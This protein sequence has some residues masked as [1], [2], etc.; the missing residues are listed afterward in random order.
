MVLYGLPRD[1]LHLIFRCGL[2]NRPCACMSPVPISRAQPKV[3]VPRTLHDLLNRQLSPEDLFAVSAQ[4]AYLR[5][6]AGADDLWRPIVL[7]RY[8]I[9]R[10]LNE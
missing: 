9:A 2:A 10:Y 5:A 1:C 6:E 8:A 4:C 3:A 7:D